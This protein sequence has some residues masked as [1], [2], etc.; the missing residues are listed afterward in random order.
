MLRHTIKPTLYLRSACFI[1]NLKEITGEGFPKLEKRIRENQY[2]A[3][4]LPAPATETVRDYFRLYLPVAFEP[5]R[6]VTSNPWLLAV[7]LEVPG[8]SAAFF[9]PLFDLLF[10][11]RKV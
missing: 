3:F 2:D 4:K 8:S 11:L 9:H 1:D 5:T 7:E 6:K 10:G